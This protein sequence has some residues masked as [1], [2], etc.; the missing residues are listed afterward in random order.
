MNTKSQL[1]VRNLHNLP[2][3]ERAKH[4]VDARNYRLQIERYQRDQKQRELEQLQ[5][6]R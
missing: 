4:I 6:K 1:L 3:Q 2:I 5:M